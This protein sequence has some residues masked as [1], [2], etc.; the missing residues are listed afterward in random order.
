MA[1]VRLAVISPQEAG[2]RQGGESVCRRRHG[3]KSTARGSVAVITLDLS[4]I[5]LD[6]VCPRRQI[7]KSGGVKYDAAPT[8]L[9]KG[10]MSWIALNLP[11]AS[12]C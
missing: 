12:V 4:F 11:F 2:R 9:P 8:D 6:R 1:W 5:T 3:I 7:A 10:S